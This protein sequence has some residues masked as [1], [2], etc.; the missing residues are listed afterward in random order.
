MYI[1]RVYRPPFGGPLRWQDDESGKLPKAMTIF[2]N[3]GVNKHA[4]APTAE[5]LEMIRDYFQYYIEAPCWQQGPG[6]AELRERIKT[7]KTGRELAQWCR[8]ALKFGIDPI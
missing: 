2:V 4:P 8:D 7:A 5:Q 3:R 1:P 6:F